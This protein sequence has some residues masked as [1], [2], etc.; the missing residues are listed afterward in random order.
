M[1]T[2]CFKNKFGS[3]YDFAH[4]TS[5]GSGNIAEVQTRESTGRRILRTGRQDRRFKT[6]FEQARLKKPPYYLQFGENSSQIVASTTVD[7]FLKKA[8]VL[9]AEAEASFKEQSPPPE[10]GGQGPA[11][12]T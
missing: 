10:A 3:T 1:T 4:S 5:K 7:D 6:A 12:E 11:P 8:E 9:I 2:S